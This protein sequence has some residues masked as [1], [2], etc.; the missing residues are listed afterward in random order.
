[1]AK[2]ATMEVDVEVNLHPVPIPHDGLERRIFP[3]QELRIEGEGDASPTLVGHAAV[4]NTLTEELWGFQERVAPGAFAESIK[5]DDVRA[6]FNHDPNLVLGRNTAGTLEMRE[7]NKGLWIRNTLPNTETGRE[8]AELVRRGDV[9]QMSFAFMTIDASWETKD[10]IEI[11]TLEKVQLFDVS[12]VTYPAYPTT[13]VS[14]R[15]FQVAIDELKDFKRPSGAR[16]RLRRAK[17]LLRVFPENHDIT[18]DTER[19]KRILAA[20][21]PRNHPERM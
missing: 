15:A 16:P 4:F 14:L 3:D 11:R 20:A 2:P 19:F 1:M 18:V 5:K 8:V 10:E 7:D 9:S 13:G 6:L 21:R 12:P 17:R